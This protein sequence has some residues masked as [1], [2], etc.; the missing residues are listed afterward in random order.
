MSVKEF[1]NVYEQ[2]FIYI[3]NLEISWANF[4][5]GERLD[6][7]VLLSAA[8]YNHNTIIGI[9]SSERDH[10]LD[11]GKFQRPDSH[12]CISHS[13]NNLASSGSS[14]QIWH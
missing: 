4:N 14:R 2:A 13:G 7:N 6:G 5:R 1:R 10:H 12:I 11:E 9:S 3:A 8:L